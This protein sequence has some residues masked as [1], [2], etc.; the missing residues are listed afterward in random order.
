M[1]G[2]EL[3]RRDLLVPGTG[4]VVDLTNEVECSLA[5]DAV[6]QFETEL[7]GIKAVL[8]DAIVDRARV[9]GTKTLRLPD[10]RVANLSAGTETV[11]DAQRIEEGLRALGMP[12]ERIR[13]VVREEVTYKVDAVEAKRVASANEQYAEVIR[14]NSHVVQKPIYVSVRR[15]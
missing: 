4:Q 11:Y 9:Q 6:R 10:G 13:E 15:R 1:S 12:E 8:T 2:N 14:D 5:L 7:K 3:E